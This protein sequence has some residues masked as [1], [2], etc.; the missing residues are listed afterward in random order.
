MKFKEYIYKYIYNII[1]V[2]HS[3]LVDFRPLCATLRNSS[4]SLRNFAQL[5]AQLAQL[6]A[7]LRNSSPSL[8]N[9]AQLV[10]QL[11]QLC[12]TLRNFAYS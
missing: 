12:A 2:P 7:T 10:A 8:R 1:Y 11:A 4:P 3:V 6:C 9:F 5:V